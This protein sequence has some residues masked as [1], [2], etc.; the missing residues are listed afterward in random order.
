MMKQQRPPEQYDYDR[1][2]YG[3]DHP[4]SATRRHGH[5]R[6]AD[7][8]RDSWQGLSPTYDP[9]RDGG[10]DASA[11]G[12]DEETRERLSERADWEPPAHARAPGDDHLGPEYEG[13]DGEGAPAIAVRHTLRPYVLTMTRADEQ[14]REAVTVRLAS[15]GHEVLAI[16]VYVTESEVTLVGSVSTRE[17]KYEAERLADDVRG[18]RDV[19]NQLRVRYDET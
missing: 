16:E 1:D 15:L 17:A 19:I 3:Y 5:H 10:A 11:D 2:R 9:L 14:T 18:V 6:Y 12:N 8:T 13:H 4:A 7:E